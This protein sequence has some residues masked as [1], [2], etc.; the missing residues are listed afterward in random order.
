[1]GYDRNGTTRSIAVDG[2]L[3]PLYARLYY[4]RAT[5]CASAGGGRQWLCGD[6]VTALSHCSA[7]HRASVRAERFEKANGARFDGRQGGG[8][9]G[10]GGCTARPAFPLY[11]SPHM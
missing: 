3:G 4:M 9:F 10:L 5:H 7:D 11:T 6:V 8:T 2:N 1:M